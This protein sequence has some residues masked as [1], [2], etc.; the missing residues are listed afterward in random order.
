MIQKAV[1]N[2]TMTREQPDPTLHLPRILCLHGGGTNARIFRTQCRRLTGH[3]NTEFRFV[4]ADAPFPSQAGPDVLSVYSQW[5]PFRRWLRWRPEQ[6]ELTAEETVKALD[7]TLNE[8]I[9]LDDLQGAT[10]EWVALLGFS[11]GAKVCA[12]L[13]YRQQQRERRRKQPKSPYPRFRFGVLLAGRAPLISLETDNNGNQ[14]AEPSPPLPDAAQM[15]DFAYNDTMLMSFKGNYLR[16]P[17]IHV[18]GLRD[19]GLELH[20]KLYEDYCEPGSKTLVQWD[21]DHRIP[22]K[23]NDVDMVVYEIREL[24]KRTGVN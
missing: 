18:H 4:F 9:K 6:P 15:T 23:R 22:L 5:G 21:G 17:T 2:K 12:S 7:D 3:L 20:R 13:L 14:G 24:A 1:E 8:A 16:V 19:Q 11:Q 10:G